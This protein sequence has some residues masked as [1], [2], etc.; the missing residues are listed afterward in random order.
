[1]RVARA[2]M[3]GLAYADAVCLHLKKLVYKNGAI[4]RRRF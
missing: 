3:L 1:M 2:R 4:I